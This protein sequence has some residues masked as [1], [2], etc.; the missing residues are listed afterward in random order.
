MLRRL[1]LC[2]ALLAVL[3][4]SVASAEAG[5]K[6]PH[7]VAGSLVSS[8][9]TVYAQPL[10]YDNDAPSTVE[11]R[12]VFRMD[13]AGTVRNLKVKLGTAPGGTATRTVV[14]RKAGVDQAVTVSFGAADTF[15]SDTTNSFAVAAGD[16]LI[17]KFTATNTPAATTYTITWEQEHAGL[18]TS[19][20]GIGAWPDVLGTSG[21]PIYAPLFSAGSWTTNADR[22]TAVACIA[23]TVTSARFVLETAPGAGRTRTFVIQKNGTDQDGTGG[24]PNTTITIADAAVTGSATFSLSVASTDLV[25]YKETAA[26]T[27]AN[28]RASGS[29]TFTSTAPGTM[30]YSASPASAP[31]ASSTTYGFPIGGDYTWS[32]TESARELMGPVTTMT[33]SGL[34]VSLTAAMG[35]GASHVYTLRKNAGDTAQTVTI[36]ATQ[37]SAGPSGGAIVTL[38]N[39]DTFATKAVATLGS[40]NNVPRMAFL[41]TDPVAAT[42]GFNA[43]LISPGYE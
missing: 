19:T 35:A 39:A 2:A 13:A 22:A 15:L 7:F 20:Y 40:V 31:T 26:G 11:A 23:G 34:Y 33:V 38:T 14:F 1:H 42:A 43:L 10:G 25:R 17:F 18:S 37:S 5:L 29:H 24:T 32:A 36:N 12:V 8:N 4:G 27:P 28:T 9:T 41:M 21:T 3:I 16:M 6:Q 30:C